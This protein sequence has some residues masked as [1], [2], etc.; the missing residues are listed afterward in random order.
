MRERRK[1]QKRFR[2][3]GQIRRAIAEGMGTDD[4]G[5]IQID[6]QSLGIDRT[7]VSCQVTLSVHHFSKDIQINMNSNEKGYSPPVTRLIQSCN[8]GTLATVKYL[9]KELL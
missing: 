2:L 7:Q 4:Y 1:V 5:T 9:L 6:S 8:D 3:R